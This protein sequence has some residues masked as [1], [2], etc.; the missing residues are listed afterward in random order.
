MTYAKRLD[1]L[2]VALRRATPF[3]RRRML[4]THK[5][6]IR[7]GKFEQKIRYLSFAITPSDQHGFDFR[8]PVRRMARRPCRRLLQFVGERECAGELGQH[9][10]RLFRGLCGY[11]FGA[12]ELPLGMHM[13]S[14]QP[15]HAR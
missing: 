6:L 13:R 8:P 7:R 12:V 11:E 10:Y 2:I 9:R 15:P 3:G 14:C 1:L 4:A 5:R